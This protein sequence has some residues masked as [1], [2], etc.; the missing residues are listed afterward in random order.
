MS[1]LIGDLLRQHHRRI[2]PLVL[3]AY[4][5]TKVINRK[6][7]TDYKPQIGD[8]VKLLCLVATIRSA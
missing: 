1:E 4:P 5:M 8:I 3:G 7:R 2:H 6:W